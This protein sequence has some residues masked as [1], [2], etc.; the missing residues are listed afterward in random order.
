MDEAIHIARKYR[1]RFN[2]QGAKLS[3][4]ADFS[5]FRISIFADAEF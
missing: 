3:W 2:F 1:I 5:N 4:V